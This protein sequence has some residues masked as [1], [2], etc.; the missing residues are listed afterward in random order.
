MLYFGAAADN[1]FVPTGIIGAA[2]DN[3]HAPS[4]IVVTAADNILASTSIDAAA[5]ISID[6]PEIILFVKSSTILHNNLLRIRFPI[7]LGSPPLTFKREAIPKTFF[8]SFLLYIF[9]A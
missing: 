1:I 2:A 9:I 7:K 5:A 8:R 3:I 6:K 4:S